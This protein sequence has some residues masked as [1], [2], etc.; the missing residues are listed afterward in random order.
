MGREREADGIEPGPEDD[1]EIAEESGKDLDYDASDAEV[2][3]ADNEV[4]MKKVCVG[5]GR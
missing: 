2:S 4:G 5:G 1:M 3:W